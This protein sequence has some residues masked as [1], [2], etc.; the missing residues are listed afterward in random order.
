MA[1]THPYGRLQFGPDL[2]LTFRTLAGQGRNPNC[3]AA[4]VIGIE[5]NWTDRIVRE[6][7][8]TGKPVRRVQHRARGRPEDD[9]GGVAQ[10]Q[11]VR[12]RR[13]RG[14]ARGVPGQPA[15]D[16]HASAASRTR[17]RAWRRTPTVGRTFERL[18]D[19]GATLIFGETTE[20][21][22]G[23]DLV[24]ELC[25][26]PGDCREVQGGVRRL[27]G[28]HRVAGREPAR[29]PA[30]RG[31]HPRRAHHDRREGARQHPEGGTLHDRGLPGTGGGAANAGPELHGLVLRGGRDGDACAPRRARSCTSSRPARATSSATR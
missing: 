6:I 29:V 16:E 31:Q 20:V 9:R 14:P 28:P 17:P 24:M 23:E 25:A 13:D 30:D 27:P 18:A 15:D 19:A 1:L 7:A 2:D 5:P 26:T 22:G 21:T 11:G 12:A 10:G 8:K 4:I 3:A